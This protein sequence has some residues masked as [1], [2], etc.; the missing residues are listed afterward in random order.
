VVFGKAHIGDL[1]N[2]NIKFGL[3]DMFGPNT[4]YVF[5]LNIAVSI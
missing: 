5:G 4:E 2:S 1:E 3:S